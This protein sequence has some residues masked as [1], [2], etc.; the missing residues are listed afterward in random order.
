MASD[1]KEADGSV[2]RR[3]FLAAA[4]AASAGLA[5]C[6]GDGEDGSGGTTTTTTQDGSDD[7]ED[8]TTTTTTE[9]PT[10]FFDQELVYAEGE[11]PRENT[12]FSPWANSGNV[13]RTTK[14]MCG[15]FLTLFQNHTRKFFPRK[16]EGWETENDR[17]T[18]VLEVAEGYT[19]NNGEKVDAEDVWLGLQ[20][21]EWVNGEVEPYIED[22]SVRDEM[23]VQI[24]FNQKVN[25]ALFGFKWLAWHSQPSDQPYHIY[26]EAGFV[27]RFEEAEQ[28]QDEEERKQRFKEIRGD[29]TGAPEGKEPFFIDA[30]DAAAWDGP[31]VPVDY[32][33]RDVYL[34]HR[35]TRDDVPDY[36]MNERRDYADPINFNRI[37]GRF[38]A[39]DKNVWAALS[40]NTVTIAGADAP[41]NVIES[42]PDFVAEWRSNGF[43][44]LKMVMNHRHPD[45]GNLNFRKALAHVI[46]RQEICNNI[47]PSLYNPRDKLVGWVGEENKK[48]WLGETY[49]GFEEYGKTQS[50]TE[51][52]AELLREADYTK[53]DGTWHRPS[54]EPASFLWFTD[55]GGFFGITGQT[56]QNALDDF[57]IPVEFRTVNNRYATRDNSD[58]WEED[59]TN[60]GAYAHW[61]GGWSPHPAFGLQQDLWGDWNGGQIMGWPDPKVSEGANSDQDVEIDQELWDV[62]VPMPVGDPD[63]STE[64]LNVKRKINQM[65]AAPDED[66]QTQYVRELSWIFNTQLPGI[67]LTAN[68]GATFY[69]DHGP[70]DDAQWQVPSF[71]ETGW[72]F[73]PMGP[74]N[75]LPKLGKFRATDR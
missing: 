6:G 14:R 4:A 48:G 38:I 9:E 28:I 66:A 22:I 15:D 36:E 11:V 5:G 30:R 63:G 73:T 31:F 65:L 60:A 47:N 33:E 74:T 10:D 42:F 17:Q 18:I 43:N 53:E 50:N 70:E 2:N 13:S 55:S 75:A 16:V 20:L 1:R 27:D 56:V 34:E 8:T 71:Q 67:P 58:W 72:R 51:R 29:L 57:G 37:R 39:Q 54:G 12:N 26:D 69:A 49:S 61:S 68:L 21:Y 45:I 24:D 23:H 59:A 64:T 40:N 25:P 44:G 19:W 35:N 52:A 32:T 7:G 41:Q 62:E 3:N 46:N